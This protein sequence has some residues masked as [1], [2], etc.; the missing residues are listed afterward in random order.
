MDAVSSRASGAALRGFLWFFAVIFIPAWTLDYWQGW[1]F[2]LTLASCTSL[3]TIYIART[4][5]TL[6]ASRLKIGPKAET[7]VRQKII[8]A[9]GAPLFVSAI[10]IM[11]LDHR[12]GWS[13]AV[14]ATMSIVGDILAAL[15]ILMY[16]LVVRENRYAAATVEVVEGQTVVSTGL[17]AVV[18]HPMYAGAVV[19]LIGMPLALASWWGLVFIPLFIGLLAGRLLDEEAF[20]S[21]H[22]AGYRDY[23]QTVRY[24][25]APFVW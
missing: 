10:V 12:F 7:N 2:F 15:G 22:L 23:M 16:F 25:L 24:R 6:L 18:R 20:L 4:D 8:T 21:R 13:L 5:K 17:Y 1:A 14:P 19:V 3:A 9:I 11:V